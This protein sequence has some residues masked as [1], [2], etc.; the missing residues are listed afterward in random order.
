MDVGNMIGNGAGVSG[1]K[2]GGKRKGIFV[3]EKMEP[4]I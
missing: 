4:V 3:E 2:A 1:D